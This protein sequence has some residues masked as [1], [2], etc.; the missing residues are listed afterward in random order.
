MARLMLRQLLEGSHPV[1]MQ[2]PYCSSM[3]MIQQCASKDM[4][5]EEEEEE[6]PFPAARPLGISSNLDPLHPCT[7]GMA[8]Q[9]LPVHLLCCIGQVNYHML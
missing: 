2:H 5:A 1:R 7:L 8:Y 4:H 9:L 3:P 6:L